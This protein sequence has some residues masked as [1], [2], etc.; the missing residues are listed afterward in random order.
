MAA[1][2]TL[3][4]VRDEPTFS[5]LSTDPERIKR[6]RDRAHQLWEEGGKLI[7]WPQRDWRQAEDEE[8]RKNP[9]ASGIIHWSEFLKNQALQETSVD[10]RACYEYCWVATTTPCSYC[11]FQKALK[12]E[13]RI[14]YAEKLVGKRWWEVGEIF[15]SEVLKRI[16]DEHFNRGVPRCRR[17]GC[18]PFSD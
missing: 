16:T 7:G 13:I 10:F 6:I 18:I 2:Q 11:G 5:R 15:L 3:F 8:Q 12:P 9:I 14:Y 17:P 1:Q 4:L